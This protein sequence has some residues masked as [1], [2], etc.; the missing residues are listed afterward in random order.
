MR[1]VIAGGHGKVALRL[2]RALA[3]RGD[4]AVGLVRNPAHVADVRAT[5]GE[6]VVCDLESTTVEAVAEHLTGADAVVFA[7]GAGPGSGIPR[8]DTVDRAASGLLADAAQAAGVRRFL[9]VSAMGV[10]HAGQAGPDDVFGAYL[11]AKRAAE[12]DLRRRPLDWTILRPGRLTDDPAVGTVR[13]AR[14]VDPGIVTRDDV[15]AVLVA[16]L[17]TA[18]A[19]GHVLELVEGDIPVPDAV[20]AAIRRA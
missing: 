14:H 15:A 16:L 3:V 18:G 12:D 2:E 7:A 20:A 4:A 5:G 8:K 6:A 10:E 9:Q 19:A 11:V 17:D 13:L 1:V